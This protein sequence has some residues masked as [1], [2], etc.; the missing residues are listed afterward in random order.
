MAITLTA[1]TLW[2]LVEGLDA[3]ITFVILGAGKE[4]PSVGTRGA[5]MALCAL[6]A[7]AVLIGGIR[8][9]GRAP[10]VRRFS[11]L[12]V[13]AS[14]LLAFVMVAGL[15]ASAAFSFFSVQLIANRHGIEA[16]GKWSEESGYLALAGMGLKAIGL[17]VALVYAVWGW[18]SAARSA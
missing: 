6:L 9:A 2:T 16:L 1:V 8:L 4:V 5:V 13:V 15:A 7:L 12:W 14:G 3:A 17:G 18:W 10:V 11:G